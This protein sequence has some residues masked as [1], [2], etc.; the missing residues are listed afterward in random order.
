MLLGAYNVVQ[1]ILNQV[2]TVLHVSSERLHPVC[3]CVC[4]CVCVLVTWEMYGNNRM[5]EVHC[6]I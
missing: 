2:T 3:V 1:V 6:D 5:R 4:V